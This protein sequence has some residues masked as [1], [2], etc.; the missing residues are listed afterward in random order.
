LDNISRAFIRRSVKKTP[1]GEE[2]IIPA[3]YVAS[4]SEISQ[5]YEKIV[6]LAR[7]D[8]TPL[9]RTTIAIFAL[10]ILAISIFRLIVANPTVDVGPIVN[11]LLSVLAGLLSA[12]VGFH[13]GARTA[14]KSEGE[15][16]KKT[17]GA[18]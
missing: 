8:M 10:I 17:E 2:K 16:P 7:M 14:E 1:D 4:P 13:F 9:A 5:M 11:N 12:V 3:T 18:K 15:T 6:T